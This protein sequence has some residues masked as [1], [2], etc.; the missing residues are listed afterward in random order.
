[1]DLFRSYQLIESGDGSYDLI[2]YMDTEMNDVEFAEEFGRIDEEN[3]KRLESGNIIDYIKEKFPNIKI[4]AVKIM[5]GSILLSTFML[6][7][8]AV[9]SAAESPT[10]PALPLY[11]KR[12]YNYNVKFL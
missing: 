7:T 1:M 6:G 11:S 4:N 12:P 10:P 2:L 9:A 3:K 8:P 5:A